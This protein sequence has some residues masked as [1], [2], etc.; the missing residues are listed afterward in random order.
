MKILFVEPFYGGS[1][2]NF[3]DNWMQRSRHDFTLVSLPARFWK[4]RMTGSALYFAENISTAADPGWD[5]MVCTGMCDLAHLKALRKDLPPAL[6]YV[7]EN[8]LAYPVSE[9]EEKDFRYGITD[10]ASMLCADSLVFNSAWN[11]DSFVNECRELFKRL[12][13]ARPESI[14]DNLVRK[15]QIIHPG[16][17]VSGISDNRARKS[18][19]VPLIIWNHRHEHDKDPATSFRVLQKLNDTG[20]NFRLALLGERFRESPESFDR[21]R[22]TIPDRIVVDEY[23]DRE[24]YL[25][26]LHQGDIVISSAMQENFGL[27]VVEAIAA[28]CRPLLPDRLAYPEILPEALHRDCLWKDENDYFNKLKI[29]LEPGGLNEECRVL[30]DE[31]VKA[32]DWV[33]IV[34]KLDEALDNLL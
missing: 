3:A 17:N 34:Q 12:P 4:W 19:G 6:L 20:I 23:P 2:R 18:D 7:H 22:S 25:D 10:L 30:L 24:S 29:L 31:H 28:G 16:V 32:Y 1:H 15:A 8:Q 21:I 11:R 13:D 27:S 26:W 33:S 14:L 9:G 5:A